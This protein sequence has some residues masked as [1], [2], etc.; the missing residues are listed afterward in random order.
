MRQTE[1]SWSEKESLQPLSKTLCISAHIT[2]KKNEQLTTLVKIFAK[3]YG[4]NTK[5]K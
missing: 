5:I 2:K 3:I 1:K 4:S